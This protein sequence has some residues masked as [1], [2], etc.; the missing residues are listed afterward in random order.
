MRVSLQSNYIL[1]L[2]QQVTIGKKGAL[3]DLTVNMNQIINYRSGE[4]SPRIQIEYESDNE[5]SL[6]GDR[7]AIC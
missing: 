5:L 7:P 3:P 4:I 6:R 2:N 1:N